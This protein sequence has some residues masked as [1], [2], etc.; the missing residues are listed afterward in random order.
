[1]QRSTTKHL[2]RVPE[3]LL[4]KGR[5]DCMS[6]GVKVVTKEPTETTDLSLL[7][8]SEPTVGEPAWDQPK[9]SVYV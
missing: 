5:K 2:G 4:K 9:P 8:A 7:T 1:M 3:V 6:Q